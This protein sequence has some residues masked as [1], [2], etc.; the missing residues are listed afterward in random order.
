M[1]SLSCFV[2]RKNQIAPTVR[3]DALP[4]RSPNHNASPADEKNEPLRKNLTTKSRRS[5]YA[6]SAATSN[7]KLVPSHLIMDGSENCRTR[8]TTRPGAERVT[9]RPPPNCRPR[10]A[11]HAHPNQPGSLV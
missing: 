3:P 2:A 5:K 8:W 1:A 10:A 4:T 11:L 6:R 7:Q 9:M